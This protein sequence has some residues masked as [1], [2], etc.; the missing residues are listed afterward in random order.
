MVRKTPNFQALKMAKYY[1]RNE[2]LRQMWFPRRNRESKN[3][4]KIQIPIMEAGGPKVRQAQL[5]LL[6]QKQNEPK[7]SKLKKVFPNTPAQ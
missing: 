3:K 5:E 4:L 6:E 2:F 7:R 1:N